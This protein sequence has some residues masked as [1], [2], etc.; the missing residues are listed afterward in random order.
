MLQGAMAGVSDASNR[1][2]DQTYKQRFGENAARPDSTAAP[3]ARPWNPPAGA[4]IQ[5]NPRTG[6]ERYTTDGGK[7]WVVQP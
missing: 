3:A 1:N 4:T 7:T 6:K 2:L 5:H